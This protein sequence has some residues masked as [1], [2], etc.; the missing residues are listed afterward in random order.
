MWCILLGK[1]Q[2]TRGRDALRGE[3]KC[4]GNAVAVLPKD[5]RHCHDA[6]MRDGTE[7][8]ACLSVVAST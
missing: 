1:S 5:L 4:S 6:G 7:S 2:S 3:D 8:L